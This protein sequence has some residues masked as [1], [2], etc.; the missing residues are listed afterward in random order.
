MESD[1]G[2]VVVLHPLVPRARVHLLVV[3]RPHFESLPDLVASG[4]GIG[5]LFK[6]ADA[7]VARAGILQTGY[8]YVLNSGPATD[9]TVP[10]PHLHILGGEHLTSHP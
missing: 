10:H 2:H 4:G 1:D 7:A 5:D 3:T 6:T 8:R 9:Q